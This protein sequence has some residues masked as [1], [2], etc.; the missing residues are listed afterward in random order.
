MHQN[1]P[2]G[3]Y[4][5]MLKKVAPYT[6]RGVIWYQGESDEFHPAEYGF[7][8]GN[9]IKGWRA[10]WN[11]ELPFLFSQL[12]PFEAWLSGT[13]VAYPELRYQ[14]DQVTKNVPQTYMASIGDAG[15]QYDIHPKHK[16]PVGERMAEL[17]LGHV[18]KQPELCKVPGLFDA[19]EFAGAKREG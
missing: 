7:V 9:M 5:T 10:L 14:Q 8:F 6:A 18:Y 12:A 16:R 19:P 13:G 11:E 17:A 3:L 2:G 1:R 4:E 15:M